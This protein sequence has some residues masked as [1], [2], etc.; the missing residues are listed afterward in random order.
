MRRWL[1]VC[2]LGLL[3]APPL[4]AQGL[5]IPTEK[6]LGPLAL[7]RHEVQ[8]EIEDQ[9]AVT[10]VT[11]TF[12]NPTSHQ[13]EAT[14][15]FPVPKGAGVKKFTMWVDGKEVSGNLVE[16][17]RPAPS[18]PTSSAGSRIPACWSTL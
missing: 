7:V 5:L 17:A 2:C 10:R 3:W 9:A 18:T 6:D 15:L 12:R 1:A 13:L 14:Y 16:A 8:I 11:Q 4:P